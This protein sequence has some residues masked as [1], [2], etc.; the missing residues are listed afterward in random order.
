[1][2][3]RFGFANGLSQKATERVTKWYKPRYEAVNR[4]VA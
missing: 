3:R 1:M 2:T 4:D